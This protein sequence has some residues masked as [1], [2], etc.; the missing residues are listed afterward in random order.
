[1]FAPGG[2]RLET[3][4]APLPGA[5][6]MKSIMEK[7]QSEDEWLISPIQ[8]VAQGT[9][10][11]MKKDYRAL[12]SPIQPTAAATAESRSGR[13]IVPNQKFQ[14]KADVLQKSSQSSTSDQVVGDVLHL[15][16]QV[17][18]FRRQLFDKMQTLCRQFAAHGQTTH[19]PPADKPQT[20]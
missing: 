18:M 15:S 20:I 4:F 8:V 6:V 19:R 1:M 16:N 9:Y 2:L 7:S 11:E 17:Q 13:T 3:P 10:E 12:S 14:D 5:P